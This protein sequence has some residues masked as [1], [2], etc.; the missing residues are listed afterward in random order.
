VEEDCTFL[1]V[2]FSFLSCSVEGGRVKAFFGIFKVISDGFLWKI[3][4]HFNESYKET[5]QQ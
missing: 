5:L 1:F 4:L 3:V 2:F